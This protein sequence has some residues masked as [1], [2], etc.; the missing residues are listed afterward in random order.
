MNAT[1]A[2]ENST[3]AWIMVGVAFLLN[4]LSF[5]VLSSVGVFLKPLAAEFGWS[6]GG[7][8]F[9]Y[10]AVTITTAFSAIFWG[11]LADKYGGRWIAVAGA[12]GMALSLLL[13]SS[14][15]SL[16]DYYVYHLLFGAIGH[17]AITGPLMAAV[18]LW[19]TRNVGLAIGLAVAGSAFGQGVVPFIARQLI[20]LHSW[21]AAYLY[22][23]LGYIVVAIPIAL[24]VKDSPRRTARDAGEPP[25][26][27]DG[28]PFPLSSTVTVAWVSAAVVFCCTAMSVPVV[29]LVPLL[30]D[31]GLTPDSAVTIF[32]VLMIAGAGGRILGGRLADIIGAL[33]GYAVMS[34]VQTSIIFAFP[35]VENIFVIY[36]LAVVFGVAFSGV[37]ASFV[38]CVRMMVPS[39]VMARSMATIGMFGWF[40]MGLGGWQGGWMFDITGNYIIP[41][42]NG[43]AAGLINI[44]VLGLFALHIR[45]ALRARDKQFAMG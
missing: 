14:V 13:L 22:L 45:H 3:Y 26:M 2:A 35:H 16:T 37:M 11:I 7:L 20:D 24:A 34:V 17:G 27:R 36:A 42:A 8:S 33:P 30:T 31:K 43:S 6:R 44:L 29:H 38:V 32:L 19:F 10:T 1:S 25:K 21:D 4:A 9:G 15:S 5:G 23:G 18:G 28:T 12:C 41:F 40:G 39:N